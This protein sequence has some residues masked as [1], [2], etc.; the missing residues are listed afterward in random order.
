[1]EIKHVTAKG[2]TFG[3][4]ARVAHSFH[5]LISAIA[6]IVGLLV[7]TAV[8]TIAVKGDALPTARAETESPSHAYWSVVVVQDGRPTL[9]LRAGKPVTKVGHPR[10][11]KAETIG[12]SRLPPTSTAV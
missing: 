7:R 11:V 6:A 5:G 2:P 1:M 12:E 4:V 3:Q 9:P 8:P 10:S